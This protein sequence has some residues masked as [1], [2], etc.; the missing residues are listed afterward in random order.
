M[1]GMTIWFTTSQSNLVVTSGVHLHIRTPLSTM[2]VIFSP[3]AVLALTILEKHLCNVGSA[4][5]ITH[6][7]LC[8]QECQSLAREGGGALHDIFNRWHCHNLLLTFQICFSWTD[9]QKNSITQWHKVMQFLHAC[10]LVIAHVGHCS[11]VRITLPVTAGYGMSSIASE[12]VTF[13]Q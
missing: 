13:P 8:H 11:S 7:I 10:A 3:L 6:M 1:E 2:Y 5:S 4:L 12:G 9:R